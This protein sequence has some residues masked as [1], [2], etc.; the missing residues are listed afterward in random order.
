MACWWWE[1]KSGAM[2]PEEGTLWSCG[3][4]DGTLMEAADVLPKIPQS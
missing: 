1:L 2:S 3:R 4:W